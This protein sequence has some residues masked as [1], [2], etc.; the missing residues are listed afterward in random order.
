M[1]TSSKKREAVVRNIAEVL[2]ENPPAHSPGA[3]SKMLV[4]PE[5]AGSELM[6][7][8]IS[9]YQPMS[10]VEPH[11]H[12]IQEQIY[13]ILQGEGLMELDGEK[14]VVRPGDFIFIPPGVEHAIYNTGTIDITFFVITTPP[15]DK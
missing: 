2:W 1:P 7:F 6:D 15:E 10:Y 13:H 8:R 11:T 14:R 3:I 9:I 12:K 5:T 4:R